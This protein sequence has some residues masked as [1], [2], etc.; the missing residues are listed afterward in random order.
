MY[1]NNICYIGLIFIASLLFGLPFFK[2]LSTDL[3]IYYLGS[4]LIDQDYKLY[5]GYF[6]FKGPIIYLYL[7]TINFLFKFGIYQMYLAIVIFYFIY[8]TTFFLI[9][10]KNKKFNLEGIIIIFLLLSFLYIQDYN[11]FISNFQIYFLIL[12]ALVAV[13][14]KQ[15]LSLIFLSLSILVRIDSILYFIPISFILLERNIL[16]FK[17]ILILICKFLLIYFMLTLITLNI[18]QVNFVDYLNFNYLFLFSYFK[19]INLDG[20]NNFINF[21][22]GIKISLYKVF[23][24]FKNNNIILEQIYYL[25]LYYIFFVILLKKINFKKI[26]IYKYIFLSITGF[27]IFLYSGSVKSYHWINL[28]APVFI[29]IL[30]IAKNNLDSLRK[31]PLILIIL[32]INIHTGTIIYESIKQRCFLLKSSCDN[33]LTRNK[34][35]FLYFNNL[36]KDKK[37]N[38]LSDEPYFYIGTNLLANLDYNNF[39]TINLG[40]EKTEDQKNLYIKLNQLKKNEKIIYP[41]NYKNLQNKYVDFIDTNILPIYFFEN[42][43]LGE[44]TKN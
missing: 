41:K 2:S 28:W 32:L 39:V 10:K 16:N 1:K 21:F 43:I 17:L 27:A 18:L 20:S 34:D 7:K 30:L 42:Y 23:F 8:L 31:F 44:V 33:F 24:Y 6:D 12:S 35:L 26:D 14:K 15:I 36:K 9:I 4:K 5:T 40:I 11:S 25:I 37:I 13:K 22:G 3:G 38:I 19:N 29:S